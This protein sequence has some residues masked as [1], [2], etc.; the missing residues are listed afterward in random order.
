MGVTSE[1]LWPGLVDQHTKVTQ[2]HEIDFEAAQGVRFCRQ[3]GAVFLDQ[4]GPLHPDYAWRGITPVAQ[5]TQWFERINVGLDE[6]E[7]QMSC[8]VKIAAH[9]SAPPGLL[10]EYY[11]GRVVQY[12]RTAEL[13]AGADLVI[14]AEGTTAVNL[15]V[16][17]ERPVLILSTDLAHPSNRALNSRYL[18]ELKLQEFDLDSLEPPRLHLQIDK[19]AYEAFMAKHVKAPRSV[20]GSIWDCIAIDMSMEAAMHPHRED[21]DTEA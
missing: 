9:P 16:I 6:V 2:L 5:V 3:G 8:G 7:R 1:S 20:D 18:R 13:V 14:V 4:M 11:Q 12:G 19:P 10:E 17:F 21:R 15:A